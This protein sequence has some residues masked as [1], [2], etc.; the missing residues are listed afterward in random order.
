MSAA[1]APAT[2]PN[3]QFV[4]VTTPEQLATVATLAHE[5]WYEFYVPLI[6]RA[7]VDYMVEKFQ[8]A[9]AMQVQIDQGYEYFLV[10]R[11]HASAPSTP[12]GAAIGSLS[13][14]NPEG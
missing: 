8:N 7:Q 13:S 1:T 4:P 3:L 9:P 2:P 10:R 6:G 12:G 11:E 5:I 14:S